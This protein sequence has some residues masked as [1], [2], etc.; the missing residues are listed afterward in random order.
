M[1]KAVNTKSWSLYSW[2]DGSSRSYPEVQESGLLTT[3]PTLADEAAAYA[4][5]GWD[6]TGATT[7]VWTNNLYNATQLGFF[8]D[9]DYWS[10]V[11]ELHDVVES[12]DLWI[13][14]HMYLRT[15][16][17]DWLTRATNIASLFTNDPTNHAAYAYDRDN[18]LLDHAPGYGL[19][20]WYEL[21]GDPD[22]ITA[23]E[24]IAL[25]IWA[26]HGEEGWVVGSAAGMGGGQRRHG[27]HLRVVTAAYELRAL[28]ADPD[29]METIWLTIL[30][31]V[32]QNPTWDSTDNMYYFDQTGTDGRWGA[33]SYASGIRGA[34]SFHIGILVEALWHCW[35]I[36]RRVD[37]KQRI[38]DIAD[39]ILLH[40]VN[41]TN[42]SAHFSMGRDSGGNTVHQAI[43]DGGSTQPWVYDQCHCISMVLAAKFT[44]DPGN[45]YMDY[46]RARLKNSHDYPG[47]SFTGGGN[48][49]IAAADEIVNY[50]DTHLNTGIGSEYLAMNKGQLPYVGFMFEGGGTPIPLEQLPSWAPPMGEAANLYTAVATLDDVLDYME[51]TGVTSF[52]SGYN[53]SNPGAGPHPATS[54]QQPFNVWNSAVNDGTWI[55]WYLGR[56]HQGGPWNALL[57]LGPFDE[58]SSP[59]WERL[60]DRTPDEDVVPQA[61]YYQDGRPGSSQTYANLI[62]VTSHPTVPKTIMRMGNGAGW[63][64]PPDSIMTEVD[65]VDISDPQNPVEYAA[66]TFQNSPTLSQ[67]ELI[68]YQASIYD[69]TIDMCWR[70]SRDQGVRTWDPTDDTYSSATLTP[71]AGFALSA[72]TKVAILEA[73]RLLIIQSETG[74]PTPSNNTRIIDLADLTAP[75]I[76]VESAFADFNNDRGGLLADPKFGPRGAFYAW[77]GGNTLRRLVIPLDYRDS[78]GDLDATADWTS[79]DVTLGGTTIGTPPVGGCFNQLLKLDNGL[80]FVPAYIGPAGQES[81]QT[82]SAVY[83][84]FVFQ[85][86]ARW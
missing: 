16:V 36:T 10:P 13:A 5:W 42:G 40:G 18:F 78:N 1:T 43:Y 34:D 66:G 53:G 11:T 27:R 23:L 56:G 84:P 55:Y 72:H 24:E 65:G 35:R 29:L 81:S 41:D 80:C 9:K 8:R 52:A 76:D 20:D 3:M 62:M 17:S 30:E 39:W 57:R 83:A 2:G 12:D 49:P 58:S 61:A 4:A 73:Q 50:V 86:P 75:Y 26:L 54:M 45:V 47:G 79:E 32:M 77:T 21:T 44:G 71:L 51:Y 46:A 15:G 69:E 60:I 6:D 33:G 7:N 70:I 82:S 22:A 28:M 63:G 74:G 25:D 31:I 68:T 64:E 37:I 67:N 48:P 85:L 38:I 14:V 19:K 59:Q